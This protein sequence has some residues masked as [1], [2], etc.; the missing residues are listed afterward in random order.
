M[1]IPS[2]LIKLDYEIA[3]DVLTVEWPDVHS[4]TLNEVNETLNEVL[5][6][7]R[8]YDVKRLLVDASLTVV[9]IDK[10]EYTKIAGNFAQQLLKT[11]LEKV[12][13]I[14][15]IDRMREATIKENNKPAP[16]GPI[17]FKN[18]KNKPEAL[19]WLRAGI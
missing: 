2:A 8:H 5:K 4:Y 17:A 3:T 6:T 19:S 11:R 7:I 18:F 15:S 16:L 1:I 13:R 14:E 10:E 9:S 12:A